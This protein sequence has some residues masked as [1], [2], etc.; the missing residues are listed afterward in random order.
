[1]PDYLGAVVLDNLARLTGRTRDDI[2]VD[3]DQTVAWV[4]ARTEELHAGVG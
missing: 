1:M 2:P 3:V 4:A